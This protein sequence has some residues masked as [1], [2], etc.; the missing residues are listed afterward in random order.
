MRMPTLLRVGNGCKSWFYGDRHWD[1]FLVIS[2]FN[3]NSHHGRRGWGKSS[4]S[5]SLNKGNSL[6]T[7]RQC[8][9]YI[10]KKVKITTR[11]TEV[12]P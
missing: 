10:K 1:I 6:M 5:N 3:A 12:A 4:N 7:S 2:S 8:S 11:V 9:S